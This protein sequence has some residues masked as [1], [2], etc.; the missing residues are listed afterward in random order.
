MN[1]KIKTIT[2]VFALIIVLGIV[3]TL[4]TGFNVDMMT[5]E[6][7]QVQI[8]LGKEFNSEDIKQ[9]TDEVFAN[10]TVEI[11]KVEVYEQQVL[12]STNEITEEQKSDL[13]TKINEK[14]E[15]EIKADETTIDLVPRVYLK[16]YII[17]HIMEFVWATILICLYVV[18]RYKKLGVLKVLVQTIL[19]L[20]I[21]EALVF[22]IIVISRI[23]I[24]NNIVT[25]MFV[26]YV[27]AIIA[28][29]SMFEN[30]LQKIKLEEKNN[31]K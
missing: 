11:Q 17:P 22:S 21:T 28:L 3:I 25:V 8:D 29:T 23:I 19:G 31:K 20:T 26:T 27:V 13:I 1:S 15:T 30:K 14:Y 18:I 5:R 4:T 2:I 24:G 7:Q 12:I 10:Q 6:H 9:I 16:D